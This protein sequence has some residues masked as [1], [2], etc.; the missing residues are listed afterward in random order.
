MKTTPDKKIAT[1]IYTDA[2]DMPSVIFGF[3][4]ITIWLDRP[5][6]PVDLIILKKHCTN[7]EVVHKQMEKQARWKCMLLVFQPTV[8]FLRVLVE[9][10]GSDV[11]TLITYVEI[12]CDTYPD[13]NDKVLCWC[14]NFLSSAHMLS[15]QQSVVLNKH[16]TTWYYGRRL[17]YNRNKRPNVLAVY[18]DKPSKLLNARPATDDPRCLHIEWRVTGSKALSRF[19]IVSVTD[20]I[21]FNFQAFFNTNIL[22]YQ[23]PNRTTDLGQV[24]TEFCGYKAIVSKTMIRK[25]A[26]KWIK[27]YSI[28]EHFVL[29]N[30]LLEMPDIAKKFTTVPFMEWLKKTVDL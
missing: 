19:G 21:L 18:A 28:D 4:R 22:M 6:L 29:H 16:Y 3:D 27:N 9:K 24:L 12:A 10:L 8:E 7:V 5:E 20:L 17:Y 23:L 1:P 25:R 26:Y 15:Q 2:N 13:T 11:C 30:A 14:G